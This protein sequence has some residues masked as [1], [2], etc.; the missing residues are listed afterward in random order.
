MSGVR[1]GSLYEF[2]ISG[3]RQDIE[4]KF[5]EGIF[6]AFGSLHSKDSTEGDGVGLAIVRRIVQGLG[7]DITVSSSPGE[8][9]ALTFSWPVTSPKQQ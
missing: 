7:G 3:N 5:Q 6:G 2:A 1:K 8:G 9:V 4:E